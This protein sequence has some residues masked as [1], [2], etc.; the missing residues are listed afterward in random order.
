MVDTIEHMAPLGLSH[1]QVLKFRYKCYTLT[2]GASIT[3][4]KYDKADYKSMREDAS[5]IDWDSRLKEKDTAHTWVIIENELNKLINKF[6]PKCTYKGGKTRRKPVWFN[7]NTFKKVR[8]KKH[9]FDRYKETLEGQLYL[10]YARARNQAKWACR[11]AVQDFE[12]NISKEA[13]YN[14]KAFYNYANSKLKTRS[15]VSDLKMDNGN[16]TA[17]V[18]EKADTL[19]KFYSSV[20]T[21]ENVQDMPDFDD[22]VDENFLESINIT[23]EM[24]RDKLSSVKVNKSPGP[25]GLHH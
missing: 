9:S 24:I 8:K 25:D 2:N 21:Q 19:N 11:K 1:H 14:V 7:E 18:K 16:I 3:K 13:K 17:N 20:F 10:E 6:V 22:R 5:N 12:R 23:D 4:V 15:G